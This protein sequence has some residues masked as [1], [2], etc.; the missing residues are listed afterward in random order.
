M[1]VDMFQLIPFILLHVLFQ[2]EN[3]MKHF[4]YS[5]PWHQKESPLLN[6]SGKT[7]Y[8]HAKSGFRK[9]NIVEM[10]RTHGKFFD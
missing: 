6:A 7:V 4:D 9:L 5:I 2:I 8:K 3:P 10:F 1:S